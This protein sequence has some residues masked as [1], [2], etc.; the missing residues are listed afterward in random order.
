MNDNTAQL[1]NATATEL[2]VDRAG[3]ILP[4]GETTDVNVDDVTQKLID[5]GSLITPAKAPEP[6]QAPDSAPK[7]R[8]S[9]QKD[10][11]QN[12]TGE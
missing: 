2:V 12:E 7:K 10:A 3:H 4:G 6:E 5:R 11:A 8:A 9:R 1:H